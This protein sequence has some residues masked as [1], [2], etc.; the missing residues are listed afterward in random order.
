MGVLDN[1]G[2]LNE[3][4]NDSGASPS[5]RTSLLAEDFVKDA[6]KAYNDN[7]VIRNHRRVSP[8]LESESPEDRRKGALTAIAME[9]TIRATANTEGK[10]YLSEKGTMSSG[11]GGIGQHI[12]DV[13]GEFYPS[14]VALDLV[15]VQPINTPKG[16]IQ[17]LKADYGSD[18]VLDGITAGDHMFENLGLGYASEIGS[19][20]VIMTGSNKVMVANVKYHVVPG[21]YRVVETTADK[22]AQ[23]GHPYASGN[24]LTDNGSGGVVESATTATLDDTATHYAKYSPTSGSSNY[25]FKATFKAALSNKSYVLTYRVDTQKSPE[26]IRD[27][28]LS[29]QQIAV[30]ALNY[31][32]RFKLSM[33]AEQILE[34][35]VGLNARDEAFKAIT[36]QIQIQRDNQII[37]NIVNNATSDTEIDFDLAPASGSGVG[38]E[39]TKTQ[40]SEDFKALFQRGQDLIRKRMGRGGVDFMLTGG[41]AASIVA[42]A[43]GFARAPI[44]KAAAGAYVLG[45]LDGVKVIVQ[46]S[47]NII[48]D[49]TFVLGYKGAGTGHSG[50]VLAEF[51]PLYVT[52]DIEYDYMQVRQGAFS[53]YDHRM[54][55]PKFYLKGKIKNSKS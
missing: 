28:D 19:S 32:I 53:M 34:K 52:P 37:N 8:L 16:V 44:D 23:D 35:T 15:D 22:T 49:D 18:Y 7:S 46:P 29:L 41:Q 33:P 24:E 39:L 1:I 54:V 14:Q 5:F 43:R 25:E 10:L 51:V 2:Y 9:K 40:R 13:V 31:P 26:A 17:V 38:S 50:S 12:V 11:L 4:N 27:I 42:S 6:E 47:A 30:E 20:T 21:T 55:Y 45:T 48:A 3:R 36:T